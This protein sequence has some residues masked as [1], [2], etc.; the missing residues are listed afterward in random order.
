MT[1]GTARGPSAQG[2]APGRY[3]LVLVRCWLPPEGCGHRFVARYERGERHPAHFDGERIARV[4]SGARRTDGSRF[5]PLGLAVPTLRVETWAGY[6][7][8]FDAILAFVRA[9][10]VA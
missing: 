8:G 1:D 6:V 9:N 7:P 3:G 5:E 2:P 10:A 4:R